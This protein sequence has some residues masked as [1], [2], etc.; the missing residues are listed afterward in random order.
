M[1]ENKYIWSP[2]KV[3]NLAASIRFLLLHP[4]LIII[5]LTKNAY[6]F[7]IN[8]EL[9]TWKKIE[10]IHDLKNAANNSIGYLSLLQIRKND[11]QFFFENILF[12]TNAMI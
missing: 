12:Q 9:P 3:T 7:I 4:K 11:K 2:A 1:L 6:L 10:I 8:I 5:E